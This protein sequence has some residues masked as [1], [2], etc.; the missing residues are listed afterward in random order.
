MGMKL[1]PGAPFFK[2]CHASHNLPLL[3]FRDWRARRFSLAMRRKTL[4]D[5][6]AAFEILP[7][8]HHTPP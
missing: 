5:K 7:E 1:P 6:H 2:G 3:A 4:S 8:K